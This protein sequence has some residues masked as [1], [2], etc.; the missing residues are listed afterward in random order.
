MQNVDA[1]EELVI[2]V[3][4]RIGPSVVF[5]TSEFY[6]YNRF[7]GQQ[8]QSGSG[9]GFVID[10]LGHI[11]TNNHVVEGANRVDVKLANGAT[12]LAEFVGT[13]PQND[14]AVLKVDVAPELLRPVELGDSS[15]LRVGQRAIAIGNP[16]GLEQSLSVGVISALG[17]QLQRDDGEWTLY[18][19]IQTD[20]AINPGNSGGPLLDSSGKVIGVNTAI[21]NVTGASIGIGFAVPVDTVKKIVPAIIE[22]GHYP[23]PWLG[24]DGYSVTPGL[25][26]LLDLPIDH[27]ILINLVERGGPARSAGLRGPSREI[28]IYNRRVPV[29]GDIILAIDGE[30]VTDMDGLIHYLETHT[31]VGQEVVVRVLRD[32]QELEVPVTVGELPTG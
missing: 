5:I 15:A 12:V 25:A 3:F 24:V 27:G 28:I 32:D 14:L 29:G 18:D 8:T 31:R 1:E 9:S 23:H 11:V 7:F 22:N 30:A 21:P 20:A 13:D 19:V 6:Y 2:G 4:D 26:E 16:L 10:Q 17:R